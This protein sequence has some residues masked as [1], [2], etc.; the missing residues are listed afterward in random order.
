LNRKL[1]AALALVL[2]G[3]LAARAGADPRREIAFPDLPDARTLKCDFHNHTIF[4]DGLVWPNVRVSEAWRQGLDA[5]AITD[6]IEYQPHSK[7]VGT[8]R[9][10]SYELMVKPAAEQDVL[11]IHGGELT[12]DTPPGHHNALFITDGNVLNIKEIDAQFDAA[13]GQN[14]FIFWNHPD[15]QGAERGKWGEVQ[16]KAFDK[17]QLQGIEI[18][19]GEHYDL[20]AHK[21][22]V[23]HGLT[24]L[25]DSDC[26]EPIAELKTS[27]TDHRTLTLVFAKERTIEAIHEALLAGRTAVWCENRLFGREK[28]LAPLF[29]ACVRI[30]PPFREDGDKHW[31]RIENRCEVEIVLERVDKVGPAKITLPSL[32]STIVRFD[33]P[34]EALQAGL[35]YRA[36]NFVIGPEKALEVKLTVLRSPRGD[37]DP[38]P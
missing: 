38:M 4:S 17:K 26:H 29:A 3:P 22:A 23:E 32:A 18:C 13:A 28:E 33:M 11:V 34:A 1:L 19:N 8:D 15:W 2:L 35:A 5:I 10:R 25:G 20:N 6:H 12:H 14:A 30:A 24:L 37:N 16:Q 7:D 9:N 31:V 21:M 36:T 27:N